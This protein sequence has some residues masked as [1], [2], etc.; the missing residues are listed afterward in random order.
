M[1]FW[2][3][4]AIKK[5]NTKIL[6]DRASALKLQG[7]KLNFQNLTK[8]FFQRNNFGEQNF[9]SIYNILFQ[10]ELWDIEEEDY[11]NYFDNITYFKECS[12]VEIYQYGNAEPSNT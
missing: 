12:E 7:D 1:L 8:N 3:W 4:L 11:Y 6:K 10:G 2:K 5:P 9:M